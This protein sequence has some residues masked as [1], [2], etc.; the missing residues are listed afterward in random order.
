M[1]EVFSVY[2][3]GTSHNVAPPGCDCSSTG[4]RTKPKFARPLTRPHSAAY[5]RLAANPPQTRIWG[6][7]IGRTSF[8]RLAKSLG[9]RTGSR[10]R[11]KRSIPASRRQPTGRVIEK[12][13]SK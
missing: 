1:T 10:A 3:C 12:A 13:K 9:E 5:Q 7:A 11:G 2:N 6:I 4:R 8:D